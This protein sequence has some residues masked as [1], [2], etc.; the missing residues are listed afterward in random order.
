[1]I[2]DKKTFYVAL[3]ILVFSLSGLTPLWKLVLTIG[4]SLALMAF[5]VKWKWPLVV[6]PK[7]LLSRSSSATYEVVEK[8]EEKAQEVVAA[9]TPIA[10]TVHYSKKVIKHPR[11]HVIKTKA[12]IKAKNTS[13]ENTEI[14]F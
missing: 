11:K 1:M 4:L 2:T 3:A 10:P 6:L 8:I 13:Q 12:K 14:K 9:I 5:S 7:K